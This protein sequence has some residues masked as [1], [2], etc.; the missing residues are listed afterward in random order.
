MTAA[1]G[2]DNL[3]KVFG[4][5]RAVDGVSLEV[6][7]GERRALIGPNGA[8]KTTLFHCVT[9]TLQAFVRL[10]AAV[11]RRRHLPAG[12]RAHQARHGAHV[13]DHQRVRRSVAGRE[14]RARDRRHRPAQMDLQ[15]AAA[16]V[17]GGS[18]AGAR[19]TGGGRPARSRRRAGQAPVLRRAPPARAGARAQHPS[20]GAVA[21]R[22]LRRA[23]AERASAHLQ[24]DPRAAARRSRW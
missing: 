23:L 6:G 7:A 22:A 1:V 12:A 15:P 4:G 18:R 17:S 10:G 3:A 5:L 2:I 16:S 8:G 19:G 14:P 9:G 13:P 20:Q 24:D 21:R 11:R